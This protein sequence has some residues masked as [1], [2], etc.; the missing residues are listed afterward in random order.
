[1]TNPDAFL[2]TVVHG[3]A[4]V[5][6]TRLG[7]TCPPPILF[8]DAEAGG[9]RFVPGKKLDWDPLR[10]DV[11]DMSDHTICRVS[12]GDTMTLDTVVDYLRTGK[13]PFVSV[14]FDSLTEYQSRLKREISPS[15]DLDQQDWGRILVKIEDAVMALRDCVERQAHM[16]CFVLITGTQF[17]DEKFRPMLQG[18]M[19]DRLS[20][21]LDA[22]GYLFTAKDAEGVARRGLRIV[23]DGKVDAGNRLPGD[24]WPEVLWDPNIVDII[25]KIESKIG[26]L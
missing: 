25:S 2:T 4:K 14:V 23:G 8:L 5:G 18:G 21:K 19:K 13:H 15:G 17:R 26:E 6:K 12:I 11:P 7:S 9:M 16:L 24:D 1:M 3:D 20:Y 10:E 22:T